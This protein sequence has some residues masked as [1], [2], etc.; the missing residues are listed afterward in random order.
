MRIHNG[1]AII[2]FTHR[3]YSYEL[4]ANNDLVCKEYP[5]NGLENSLAQG[6]KYLQ[7]ELAW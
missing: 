7:V 6:P 2:R 4:L 3:T 5:A 1:V